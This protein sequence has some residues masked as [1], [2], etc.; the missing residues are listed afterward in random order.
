MYNKGRLRK[1]EWQVTEI[2]DSPF[3]DKDIKITLERGIEDL[4]IKYNKKE[5]RITTELRPGI[6]EEEIKVAIAKGFLEF[7]I[8]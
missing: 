3:D 7:N 5:A 8:Y 6:K 1:L 4:N 2:I